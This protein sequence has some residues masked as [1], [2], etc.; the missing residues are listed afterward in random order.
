ME[1][2]L[3]FGEIYLYIFILNMSINTIS[4]KGDCYIGYDV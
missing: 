3:Y 2:T 4:K 1:L